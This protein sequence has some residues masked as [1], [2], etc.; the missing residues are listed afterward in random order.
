MWKLSSC[1]MCELARNSIL[2][3]GFEDR[4]KLH[5]L[6]PNFKE[7]VTK[8]SYLKRKYK[9]NFREFLAM[10]FPEPMSLIFE[11]RF[12]ELIPFLYSYY[13]ANLSNNQAWSTG[14][15]TM[16]PVQV[17]IFVHLDLAVK[18]SFSKNSPMKWSF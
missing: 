8:D 6:G 14:Q 9:W 16:Q 2:Q 11:S 15:W 1:D 13:N 18:S 12:G 7:E 4:V 10:T 5:W 3:S 17:I